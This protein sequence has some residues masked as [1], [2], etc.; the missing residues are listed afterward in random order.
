MT[1]DELISLLKERFS[2]NIFKDDELKWQDIIIRL[3]DDVLKSLIYMEETGGQVDFL[4]F[5]KVNDKYVF[6]DSSTETAIGRRSICYDE[7][8]LAARKKNKPETSAEKLAKDYDL[9]LMSEEEYFHLQSKKDVDLKTSSWLK[10][11]DEIRSKGGALFGS[12]K[13]GRTFI[14]HNGADSY[15]AV[16]SF[17]AIKKI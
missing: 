3:I 2:E 5:D 13:Y 12:K 17:R 15:Y 10:T 7:K 8:A 4:Y 1:N 9:E 6:C 11:P 14:Y 16:R